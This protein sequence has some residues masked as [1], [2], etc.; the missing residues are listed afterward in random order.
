MFIF[1]LKIK[2]P[3]FKNRSHKRADNI[4]T[5]IY[6]FLFTRSFLHFPLPL[7]TQADVTLH[8]ALRDTQNHNDDVF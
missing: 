6:S 8:Q 3:T 5:I 7:T 2:L 4:Q 1:K